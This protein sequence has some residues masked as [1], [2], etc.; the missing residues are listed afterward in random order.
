MPSTLAASPA[1]NASLDIVAL[2]WRLYLCSTPPMLLQTALDHRILDYTQLAF[3]G[4]AAGARR[5]RDSLQPAREAFKASK[6]DGKPQAQV[7]SPD[8]I[9]LAVPKAF[10]TLRAG[11]LPSPALALSIL[12]FG[13]G[14]LASY[15]RIRLIEFAELPKTIS[16]KIRRVELRRG[17]EGRAPGARKPGEYGMDDFADLRR[18]RVAGGSGILSRWSPS[19]PTVCRPERPPDWGYGN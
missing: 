7:P 16:G 6:P 4:D 5:V 11:A 3:A 10:V 8:P 19:S 17:E 18:D 13:H 14:R 15:K 1:A 9:R 2:G 12:Q